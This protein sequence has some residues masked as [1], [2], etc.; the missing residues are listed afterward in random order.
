[1]KLKTSF[2]NFTVLR[3]NLIRFAPFLLFPQDR[4]L[5]AIVTKLSSLLPSA[6]IGMLVV[7]CLKGVKLLSSPHGIPEMVSCAFVVLLHVWKRNTL[8][9]IL[10]GT[11]LYMILLQLVFA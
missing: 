9:S 2:F 6:V 4:E 7:Y 3:K 10:G 5:P 11:V 1:M 8:L